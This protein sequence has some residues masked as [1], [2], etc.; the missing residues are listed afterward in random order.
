MQVSHIQDDHARVPADGWGRRVFANLDLILLVPAVVAALA[1]GAPAVG[2]LVGAFAWIG[3]R[4]LA[5]YD[6]RWVARNREPRKRLGW[7]LAEAF[8]R[9]WLLAGAIVVA[10]VAGGHRDGLWAALT[11]FFAYT[12]AFVVRVLSGPPQPGSPR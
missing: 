3:Q 7:S 1:L 10:G 9:I 12:V 5:V 6:G 8:G 2:V 4:V 11:I